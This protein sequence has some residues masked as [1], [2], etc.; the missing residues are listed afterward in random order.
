MKIYNYQ[1]AI[2]GMKIEASR[3]I[4]M[5]DACH[6]V[7]FAISKND[8]IKNGI[9]LSPNLHRAFDRGLIT[10][11]ND[12]T[13]VVTSKIIESKSSYSISQFEGKK[14]L[15]PQNYNFYPDTENLK[16]HRKE[17]FRTLFVGTSHQKRK[18]N[19]KRKSKILFFNWNGSN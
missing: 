11:N 17:R 14:N 1:C 5:I 13:V 6:I 2:S 15:L 3:N 4:Q 16:W 7:P 9:S 18:S 19:V 12:Y 8:T 10:I